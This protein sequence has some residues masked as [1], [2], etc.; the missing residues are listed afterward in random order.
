MSYNLVLP[1]GIGDCSWAVSALW[2]VRDQIAR[3]DVLEGWPM[4]T[5]PYL[6]LMGFDTAYVPLTYPMILGFESDHGIG[7]DSKDRTWEKI[8]NLQVANLLLEPNKWLEA[9]ERLEKWLPDLPCE[10]HYPLTVS[11]KDRD[12][13]ERTVAREMARHPMEHGPVVGISCAS[14]RGAEA[15]KTWGIGEW[16]DMLRRIMSIG[17]RPLLLGGHWDDLTYA[18]AF[19]LELPDIVGK[20]NV[21]QMV[22]V[23]GMLD[24]YIGYSSGMN[25]IR[26]VLDKP[27]M[28]LWPDFQNEL[29]DSWA[30]PEMLESHRYV[31]HLWREPKIVWPMAKGFLR[32]CE[33]ELAVSKSNGV[34]QEVASA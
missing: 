23:M 7:R 14:Y 32:R 25:V 16:K 4:R 15:W 21:P 19:D 29:R 2:S 12:R 28:A 1:S 3:W 18:V 17:W 34:M 9:G 5:T 26:T 8:S 31:S 27:A 13:A 33:R 24:A 6:E 20:T 30:P 22:H 10:F 11:A